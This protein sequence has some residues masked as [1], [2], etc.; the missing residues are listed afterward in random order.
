MGFIKFR[1]TTVYINLKHKTIILHTATTETYF[2]DC[3]R[4][5]VFYDTSK[6]ELMIKPITEIEYG[7][8]HEPEGSIFQLN[9]LVHSNTSMVAPSKVFSENN[10]GHFNGY[11]TAI[12]DS[13]NKWLVINPDNKIKIQERRKTSKEKGLP[14]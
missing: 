14:I 1:R 2:K 6:K 4:V 11:Y 10:I 3:H 13:G 7:S 9:Y 12:W 5:K 8:E